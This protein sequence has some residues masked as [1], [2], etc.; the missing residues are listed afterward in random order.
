M[1]PTD[2]QI[3]S[4]GCVVNLTVLGYNWLTLNWIRKKKW[5]DGWIGGSLNQQ[6]MSIYVTQVKSHIAKMNQNASKVAI[7]IL[8]LEA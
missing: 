4:I 2:Q 7:K 6:S 8:F 3:P 1:I 5:M